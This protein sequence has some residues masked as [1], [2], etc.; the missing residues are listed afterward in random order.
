MPCDCHTS[1]SAQDVLPI[2]LFRFGIEPRIKVELRPLP[3]TCQRAYKVAK[4]HGTK[5]WDNVLFVG[6]P[7]DCFLC[8]FDIAYT[9]CGSVRE[10]FT[11]R[12]LRIRRV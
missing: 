4:N 1:H 7:G 5:G 9:T 8:V 12:T 10:G 3:G 6:Q 11:L 2:F